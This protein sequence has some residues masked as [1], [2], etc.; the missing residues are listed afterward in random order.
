MSDGP[1][2]RNH[3][4]AGKLLTAADLELEQNYFRNKSKLHN[5]SLHGFGIVSGL[6]VSHRQ[7]ELIIAP[8]LALDCQG[9]E[10]LIAEPVSHALPDQSSG[11]TVYLTIRY[12]EEET[13]PTP[14]LLSAEL[15]QHTMIAETFTLT[16]EGQNPNQNHRHLH[17]RWQACGQSHG[18]VLARLRKS[19][20]QWR[21]DRRLRRPAVK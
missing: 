1:F 20:G 18:L 15:P 3:F 21:I 17:G 6:E 16:F 19:S 13:G 10:I 7:D 8:G 12:S 9:N 4:F 2:I 5:R 14:D 11:T